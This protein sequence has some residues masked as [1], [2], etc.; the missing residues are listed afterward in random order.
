MEFV[1]KVLRSSADQGNW[2]ELAFKIFGTSLTTV[3]KVSS[4]QLSLPQIQNTYVMSR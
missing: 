1:C 3:L 4:S 2:V